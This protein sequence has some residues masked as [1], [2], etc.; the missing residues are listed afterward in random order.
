MLHERWDLSEPTP[1]T[2]AA[3]GRDGRATRLHSISSADDGSAP[4]PCRGVLRY[5]LRSGR[6]ASSF[7]ARGIGDTHPTDGWL[8]FTH[9]SAAANASW[10]GFQE[11]ADLSWDA[12]PAEGDVCFLDVAP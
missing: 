12:I 2:P 8:W 10:D 6:A 11:P 9:P 3:A 7:G 1:G 5:M 4:G